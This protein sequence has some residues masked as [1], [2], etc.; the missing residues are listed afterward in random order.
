MLKG[1]RS[2]GECRSENVA[3]LRRFPLFDSSAG[4]VAMYIKGLVCFDT[5]LFR[6][7]LL[8]G[9]LSVKPRGHILAVVLF[10]A[11]PVKLTKGHISG[12]GRSTQGYFLTRD[13]VFIN[14]YVSVT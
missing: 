12:S 9:A 7:Q 11:L 10:G 6:A 13:A 3:N 14:I 2:K 4:S 8:V 1:H 5:E